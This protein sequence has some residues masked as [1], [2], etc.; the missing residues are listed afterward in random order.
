M[1]LPRFSNMTRKAR[2]VLISGL[3]AALVACGGGSGGDDSGGGGG[4][5]TPPPP[6]P[7]STTG[8]LSVTVTDDAR[9]A[10][11]GAA[12]RVT[13]GTVALPPA[14]TGPNGIASIPNVPAGTATVEAS[15]DP[16]ISG[17]TSAP[18]TASQTASATVIIRR[19]GQIAAQVR[20]SFGAPV[21]N[22]TVTASIEGQVIVGVTAVNGTVTLQRVPTGAVSVTTTASGF[23]PSAASV[24]TVAQAPPAPPAIYSVELQRNVPAVSGFVTGHTGVITATGGTLE[25]PVRVFVIDASGQGITNLTAANFA[26]QNCADTN[27][28][29]FECVQVIASDP[30]ID[31]SYSASPAAPANWAL[32][33]GVSRVPYLT[34]LMLDSSR[35]I[36]D[37]DPT[38][39][40]IFATKVFLDNLGTNDLVALSAF[41]IGSAD[42]QNP[43]LIPPPPPV[44][45][46]GFSSNGRDFFADLDSLANLEGGETPLYEALTSMIGYT[47]TTAQGQAT[48]GRGIVLFTDGRDDPRC[49]PSSSECRDA[50]ITLANQEPKVKVFTVGLLSNRQFPDLVDFNALNQLAAGTEGLFLYADSA[51][52]LIPIYRSLGS[53]VSNSLP[54]YT[55]R[56]R[57]EAARNDIFVQG[58]SVFGKIRVTAGSNQF[59]LPFVVSIP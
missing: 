14:T 13:V 10:I 11:D 47:R 17:T 38:D 48:Q 42:G 57:I 5:G 26:L 31:A 58:T 8:T 4:G 33:S 39:A 49:Q 59:D 2:L 36:R 56:L 15:K 6:P 51:D 23:T 19:T 7:P 3:A 37:T 45:V 22:A 46:Y 9:V 40:R 25:F 27:P 18:I 50:A 1:E 29:E 35:S 16:Y 44:H 24:V 53:L 52:Q 55:M 28:T 34:S 30:D 12:V 20:D 32:V 41:A 21:T 43:A 54:S